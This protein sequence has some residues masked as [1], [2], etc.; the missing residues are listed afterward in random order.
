M[1]GRSDFFDRHL[2]QTTPYPF[3]LEI[4]RAKGVWLYGKDGKRW[5]DLISGVGVSAIG[6]GHPLVVEA[7]KAQ[8]D[9]HLHVMVYGEYL[10]QPQTEA[11]KA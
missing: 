2:A 1:D 9:K 7:I 3:G 11:A 4:E 10:Q 8:A 6:H 5:M